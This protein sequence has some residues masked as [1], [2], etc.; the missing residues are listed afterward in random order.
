[1]AK[2]QLR[3]RYW[4]GAVIAGVDG[5]RKTDIGEYKREIRINKLLVT[6]KGNNVGIQHLQY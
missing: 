5:S 4:Y 1:M 3:M 6:S 2:T